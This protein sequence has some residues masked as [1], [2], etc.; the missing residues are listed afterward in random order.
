M[1]PLPRSVEQRARNLAAMMDHLDIWPKDSFA[2]LPM[3]TA[4]HTC[5]LCYRG[6]QCSRWLAEPD[7]DPA[8]WRRFCPNAALFV[9]LRQRSRSAAAS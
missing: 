9:E 1:T 5:F 6:R 3:E 8:G 2:G 4:V 7:T